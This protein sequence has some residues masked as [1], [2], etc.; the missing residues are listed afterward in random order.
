MMAEFI[1]E[2]KSSLKNKTNKLVVFLLRFFFV[3]Q[4]FISLFHEKKKE[5]QEQKHDFMEEKCQENEI[6]SLGVKTAN[7]MSC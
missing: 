1:V 2:N 4:Y 6:R 3:C 5:I 7:E